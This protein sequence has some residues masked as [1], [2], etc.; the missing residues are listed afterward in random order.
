MVVR[1]LNELKCTLEREK[2]EMLGALRKQ[3]GATLLPPLQIPLSVSGIIG[4]L[5]LLLLL[6]LEKM[7]KEPAKQGR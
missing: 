4:L 7:E 2:R 1:V 3:D 5:L 6:L